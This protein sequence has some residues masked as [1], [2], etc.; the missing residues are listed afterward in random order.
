MTR[1]F[2]V[3]SNYGIIASILALGI[4]HRFVD[5]SAPDYLADCHA[6]YYPV[7]WSVILALV[8]AFLLLSLSYLVVLFIKRFKVPRWHLIAYF[9]GI[10]LLMV[11]VYEAG[12]ERLIFW[13]LSDCLDYGLI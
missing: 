13:L 4:R 9:S 8:S 2:Q 7:F 10:L 1:L 12:L 11:G 6:K 3:F 5:S